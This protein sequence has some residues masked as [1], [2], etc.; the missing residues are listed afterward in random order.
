MTTP[1][2]RLQACLAFTLHH[3]GGYQARPN[4]RGNWFDGRLIG[5][6]RGIS[7]P[8]LAAWMGQDRAESLT[9]EDMRALSEGDARAIYAAHY[10]NPVRGDD[11][12]AGLDLMLFDLAVLAGPRRSVMILQ[13]Q[14]ARRDPGQVALLLRRGANEADGAR[15]QTL[16]GKSEI[17]QTVVKRQR[18]A[19]QAKLAGVDRIGR[20]A[21]SLACDGMLEPAAAAEQAHQANTFGVHRITAFVMVRVS[22]VLAAPNV[23]LRFEFAVAVVKERPVQFRRVLTHF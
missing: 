12:V 20:R 21:V 15:T 23:Q 7:A 19:Q 11:L 13:A 5:T 18:L 22:Q 16:H 8:T 14:L 1:A 17:G 9:A 3:E 2:E 4:D 6:N 10:W